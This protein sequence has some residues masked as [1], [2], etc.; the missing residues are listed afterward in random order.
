M[1]TPVTPSEIE[2][3]SSSPWLVEDANRKKNRNLILETYDRLDLVL[4]ILIRQMR[5][6][7][8]LDFNARTD[9][10]SKKRYKGKDFYML[11]LRYYITNRF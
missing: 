6:Y 8:V 1:P 5:K 3:T 4:K 9:Y 7:F 11:M 10:I 2:N